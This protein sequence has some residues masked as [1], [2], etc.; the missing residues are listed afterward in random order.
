MINPQ[1][2]SSLRRIPPENVWTFLSLKSVNSTNLSRSPARSFATLR[3]IP[4][5]SAHKKMFSKPVKSSSAVYSCGTT[6]ITFLTSLSCF[7]TSKPKTDA[8]PSV[9]FRI[10][11]SMLIVV[12]F[13]A[14]LGPRK[15][16]ISPSATWKETLSTATSCPKFLD[17][18]ST[19]IMFI[20]DFVEVGSIVQCLPDLFLAER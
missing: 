14:P 20:F 12:V 15:P 11:I 2:S 8:L 7:P 9:G 10:V 17:S 13:P 3:G 19:S 5:M 6:P 18:S 4:Y 16:N 1:A